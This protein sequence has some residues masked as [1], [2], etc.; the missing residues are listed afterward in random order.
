MARS[1]ANLTGDLYT[2]MYIV[3]DEV[4]YPRA[5]G[6]DG[7]VHHNAASYDYEPIIDREIAAFRAFMQHIK[8]VDSQTHT[9]LMIQV[10]NEIAVFGVD[11]KN[12]EMWRD[13]SPAANK[14]FTDHGF[15]D[16]LRFNGMGCSPASSRLL[17]GS[18]P[19]AS[20]AR[21]AEHV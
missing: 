4:T 7:V 11:R 18:R 2:P 1:T 10:E 5:V 16:D 21:V 6:E 9:I 15:T 14:R 3:E 20:S 13:H 12:P 17:A 8:Q 19:S